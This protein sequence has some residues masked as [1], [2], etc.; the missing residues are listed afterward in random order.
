[1]QILEQVKK[2]M[3]PGYSKLLIHDLI[4]PERGADK[5]TAVFDLV[6]M[7][8]N[9]GMERTETQWRQLLEK[10]G[11]EVI[12][13]WPPPEAGADGIIE[14]VLKTDSSLRV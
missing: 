14:A 10:A 2:A 5:F 9:A 7:A 12:K 8:F 3:T 4:V 13:A 11:F 1:M 6:M